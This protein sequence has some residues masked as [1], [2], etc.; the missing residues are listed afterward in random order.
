MKCPKCG[1]EIEDGS[2]FCYLCGGNIAKINEK[3][4]EEEVHLLDMS[5]Y[6]QKEET[7]PE[8]S[9]YKSEFKITTEQFDFKC[10]SVMAYLI[11]ALLCFFDTNYK[12]IY[13]AFAFEELSYFKSV[14]PAILLIAFIIWGNKIGENEESGILAK[15][16]SVML[17]ASYFVNPYYYKFFNLVL[18]VVIV[19]CF[20]WQF[21]IWKSISYQ[22]TDSRGIL[23]QFNPVIKKVS[24]IGKEKICIGI[25]IALVVI[26]AIA[27]F[28]PKSH[29]CDLCGK[30]FKGKGYSNM[31]TAEVE[32]GL[33]CEDCA[34][35]EYG[36]DYLRYKR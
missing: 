26:G 6:Y 15:G 18:F 21:G 35:Y 25:V 33:L 30:T 20:V 22:A 4:K 17:I 29:V 24:S 3:K 5:K 19:V 1:K 12:C 36:A 31:I 10:W 34:S 13:Y 32:S 28:S 9:L 7:S 11:S 8:K 27:L 16:L 23:Y 2:K 14:I